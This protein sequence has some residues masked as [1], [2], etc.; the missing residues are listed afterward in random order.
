MSSFL[1]VWR[2]L[3][4]A[5][6]VSPRSR[7]FPDRIR[8][9]S[10]HGISDSAPENWRHYARYFGLSTSDEKVT[11]QAAPAFPDNRKAA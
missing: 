6:R 4:L 9:R 3:G 1:S 8:A 2:A 7:R 10:S 11:P 5:D